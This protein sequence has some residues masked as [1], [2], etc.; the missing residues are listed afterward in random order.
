MS[1]NGSTSGNINSHASASDVRSALESLLRV[2]KVGGSR[3]YSTELETELMTC[4][5]SVTPGSLTVLC[6]AASCGSSTTLPVSIVNDSSVETSYQGATALTAISLYRCVRG[7]ERTVT[8]LSVDGG[9]SARVSALSY[10]KHALNPLTASIA[11]RPTDCLGC[12][13]RG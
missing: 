9:K 8:F 7:C 1:C 3:D 5:V 2:H 10:P 12:F 4:L 13:Y 11:I 6:A